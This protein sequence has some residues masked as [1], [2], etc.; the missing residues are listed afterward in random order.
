MNNVSEPLSD[1]EIIGEIKKII[2]APKRH[3]NYMNDAYWRYCEIAV[4][5]AEEEEK[6][7]HE[8]DES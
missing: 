3:G 6:K 8:E 1:S 2:H 5:L 4:L 7:R